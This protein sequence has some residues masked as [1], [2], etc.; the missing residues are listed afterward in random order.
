M[1]KR[2]YIHRFEAPPVPVTNWQELPVLLDI[3]T[4]ARLLGKKENNV[5]R[6]IYDGELP[7]RKAGGEWRLRKDEIMLCMGYT[8]AEVE[9]FGFNMNTP[10]EPMTLVERIG[11]KEFMYDVV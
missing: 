3:P 4:A 6:L 9:R 10:L 11:G 2:K 1:G 7:A 8:P 5:R